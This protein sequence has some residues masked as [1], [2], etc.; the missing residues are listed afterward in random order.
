MNV[1]IFIDS[2]L[3]FLTFLGLFWKICWKFVEFQSI[4]N[5]PPYDQNRDGSAFLRVGTK[6]EF[7]AY[8]I[9]I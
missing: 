8:I 2:L 6:Q 5:F 7:I 3:Y 1:S 9:P 4:L